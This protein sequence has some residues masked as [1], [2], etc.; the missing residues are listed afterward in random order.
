[1]I[2]R[3]IYAECLSVYR[4]MVAADVRRESSISV[5]KVRLVHKF[6][7]S[8]ILQHIFSP[9]SGCARGKWRNLHSHHHTHTLHAT[10]TIA[11]V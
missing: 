11:R 2:V 7:V 1:M 8:S 10:I 4:L 5:K 3:A 6:R 9:R